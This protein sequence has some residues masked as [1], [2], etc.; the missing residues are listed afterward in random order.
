M[1]RLIARDKAFW[2][3]AALVLA[4]L[5]GAA[6]LK[7]VGPGSEGNAPLAGRQAQPQGGEDPLLAAVLNGTFPAVDANL[8]LGKAFGSYRWFSGGPKWLVRGGTGGRVVSVTAALEVPPAAARLGVG[9]DAAAVFY[10]AEFAVSPDGVSFRPVLSAVEMR[11]AT[12]KLLAR[13]PDPE[14]V[15]VRRVM[16]GVEPSLNL[17]GQ[18]RKAQ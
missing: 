6:S 5:G 11:D 12:N 1:L 14:F 3:A 2:I 10:V 17:P 15:L 4:L 13:V 9:S 7:P 18:P 8:T 16:R